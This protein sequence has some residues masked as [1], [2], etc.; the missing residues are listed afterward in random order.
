MSK[1]DI[2]KANRELLCLSK[3]I[4]YRKGENMLNTK[5]YY[6]PQNDWSTN[7]YY[8]LHR[9]LH[10]LVTH[11]DRKSDEI[12]QLDVQKMSDKT[13]VLLYCIISYYH[14]DKLFELSNLQRLTKCQL[15]SEPFVLSD[16]GLR[17]ENVY[18]KM[19][20]LF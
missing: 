15:L 7:D 2:I 14:L 13:K 12:A 5:P 8:S 20:V 1:R 4:S 9:Y 6:A 3:A 16:H 17:E 19:N 18:Y 11:A 10:R